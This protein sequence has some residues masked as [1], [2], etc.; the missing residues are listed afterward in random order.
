MKKIYS[1]PTTKFVEVNV[2]TSVMD[3]SFAPTSEAEGAG[4]CTDEPMPMF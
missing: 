1:E 3:E 2:K 4:T